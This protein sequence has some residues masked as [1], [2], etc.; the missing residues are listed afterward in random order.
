MRYAEG[1]DWEF[2]PLLALPLPCPAQSGESL[3]PFCFLSGSRHLPVPS[4]H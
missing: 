4:C 2:S 1:L 3:C